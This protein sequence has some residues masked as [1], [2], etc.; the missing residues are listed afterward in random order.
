M[1][2]I[3]S[4]EVLAKFPPTLIITGTRGFELSSALYTH[5]QLVKPAL[6]PICMFGKDSF[7]GSSTT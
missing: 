4:P 7:T 2:P 6:K 3:N 1:S 5:E